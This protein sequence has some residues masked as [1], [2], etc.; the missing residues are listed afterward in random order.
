MVLGVDIQSGE[1]SS[2]DDARATMAIYR[3]QKPSWE[4]GLKTHSKPTLLASTPALIAALD[5]KATPISGVTKSLKPKTLGLA[6]T[7]RH[8]RNEVEAEEAEKVKMG[9]EEAEARE[10]KKKDRE[11]KDGLVLGFD[12]SIKPVVKKVPVVKVV[13]KKEEGEEK[14]KVRKVAGRAFKGDREKRPKST[15]GWWE[16]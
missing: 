12:Y 14:K 11:D 15:E 13:K 1:H 16:E 7:I 9:V 5:P 3:S 4:S 10:A 8:A 6:A 2:V